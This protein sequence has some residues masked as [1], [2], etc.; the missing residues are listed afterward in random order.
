VNPRGNDAPAAPAAGASPASA[1]P[2]APALDRNTEL[3]IERNRFAQ[4]RTLLAWLRTA[5]AMIGFGMTYVKFVE[6]TH[7]YSSRIRGPGEAPPPEPA[8]ST[9]VGM[10]LV[11]TGTLALVLAVVQHR[12]RMREY[13]RLG[14]TIGWDLAAWVAVAIAVVGAIALVALLV[15]H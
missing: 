3:A 10:L 14:M 9:W 12:A 6:W 11:A 13:G 15:G 5:L 7:L 8:G 4:E 1:R 2:P